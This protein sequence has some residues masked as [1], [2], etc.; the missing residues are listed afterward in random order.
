MPLS[1]FVKSVTAVCPSEGVYMVMLKEE[2]VNELVKRLSKK[3]IVE[4]RIGNQM[5]R[6]KVGDNIIAFFAPNKLLITLGGP[7]ST[8]EE[9]L[10][11]LLSD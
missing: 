8:V 4:F 9:L 11:K 6:V 10:E 2:R 7:E 3:G 1:D 5:L